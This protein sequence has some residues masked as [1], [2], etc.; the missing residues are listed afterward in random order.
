[1]QLGTEQH[2]EVGAELDLGLLV[3]VT[4]LFGF[5]TTEVDGTGCRDDWIGPLEDDSVG[6]Q[7]ERAN[8]IE[9]ESKFGRA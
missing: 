5:V 4:M 6:G 9:S 7:P 8:V 1:M 2:L 3:G